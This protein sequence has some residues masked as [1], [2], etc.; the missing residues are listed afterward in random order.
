MPVDVIIQDPNTGQLAQVNDEGHQVISVYG[1]PPLLPQKNR[2]FADYV[3]VW[4]D[5]G[6]IDM[7]IN[8]AVTPT[9]FWIGADNDDDRYITAIS[10]AMGYGTTAQMW[11]FADSAGA[12]ANGVL[13]NYIDSFNNLVEIANFTRNLDFLRYSLAPLS[14]V[15]YEARGFS[16]L[17]DYG[18]FVTID[19]AKI[20]PP[21]GIKLDRGS[22]QRLSVTIRDD[23]T[24]ADL[25]TCRAF[26]FDRFE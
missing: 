1:C 16:V 12:L 9:E 14:N 21:H 6:K 20:L 15:G 24:D 2:V 17:N 5:D 7:G 19:L 26:G 18:Y 13:I 8:G 23:C 10:F 11:E 22:I 4:D 3:R 25:F